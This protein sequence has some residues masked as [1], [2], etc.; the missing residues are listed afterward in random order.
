MGF[1]EAASVT[2]PD[3]DGE[4][5]VV[6]SMQPLTAMRNGRITRYR[7][8]LI[9]GLTVSLRMQ[10]ATLRETSRPLRELKFFKIS[11]HDQQSPLRRSREAS[12]R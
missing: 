7:H 2:V 1:R 10:K 8:V 11:H 4:T 12:L 9:N 5:Y 3:A 6:I